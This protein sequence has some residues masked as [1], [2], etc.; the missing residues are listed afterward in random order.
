MVGEAAV[1][2]AVEV[3]ATMVAALAA[4]N[5]GNSDGFDDS[6][7]GRGGIFDDVSSSGSCNDSGG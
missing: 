5:C 1:V 3:L 6:S 2:K 7:N 4:S